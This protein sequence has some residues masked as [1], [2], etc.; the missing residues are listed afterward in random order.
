MYNE[1]TMVV[2]KATPLHRD[3]HRNAFPGV[4]IWTYKNRFIMKKFSF[5][6]KHPNEQF[7]AIYHEETM[8]SMKATPLL[9]DRHRNTF[10]G[11]NIWT[12]KIDLLLIF[13]L[14]YGSIPMNSL[15]QFIKKKQWFQ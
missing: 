8:V 1:E 6:W 7:N 14:F 3:R 5:L 9:R 13:F 12:Y 11:V 4:N 10:P 15:T 2:M